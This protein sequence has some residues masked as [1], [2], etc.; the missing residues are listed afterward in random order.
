MIEI[1]LKELPLG[2]RCINNISYKMTHLRLVLA[3]HRGHSS[4][5]PGAGAGA[6]LGEGGARR[7]GGGYSFGRSRA[8]FGR[9]SSMSS[10]SVSSSMYENTSHAAVWSRSRTAAGSGHVRTCCRDMRPERA[11]G[12]GYGGSGAAAARGPRPQ[13][14]P[15]PVQQRVHEHDARVHD[16]HAHHGQHGGA[17]EVRSLEAIVLLL[18]HHLR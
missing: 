4:P 3:A 8:G 15:A 5:A 1:V 12:G 16:E 6:W 11:G 13:R 10:N 18:L 2:G 14:A 7:A 9:S 17:A